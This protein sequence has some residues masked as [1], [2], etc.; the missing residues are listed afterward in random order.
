MSS[1]SNTVVQETKGGAL[2]DTLRRCRYLAVIALAGLGWSCSTC[3]AHYVLQTADN[4][5]FLAC[6]AI[7]HR[8]GNRDAV[9]ETTVVR[10]GYDIW[11]R[12]KH[13]MPDGPV[14]ITLFCPGYQ[15]V[16]T[17]T[18]EWHP[19]VLDEWGC[20]PVELGTITLPRVPPPRKPGTAAP[21][22]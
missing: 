8:A 12:R 9:L 11:Y 21:P 7:L 5:R 15:T 2:R 17:K 10:S 4:T 19:K 14:A 13:S 20:D 16:T 1:P 22:G 3:D 18:F 6:T